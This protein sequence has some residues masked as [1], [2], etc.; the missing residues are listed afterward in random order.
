MKRRK[1]R[2][3][4]ADFLIKGILSVNLIAKEMSMKIM[5]MIFELKTLNSIIHIILTALEFREQAT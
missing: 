1:R 2:I 3:P 4:Q 5:Q